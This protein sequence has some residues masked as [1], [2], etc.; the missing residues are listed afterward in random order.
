ML[1]RFLQADLRSLL[2]SQ[3]APCI[4]MYLPTAKTGA[5]VREG[6]I[7]LKNLAN[8][9]EQRL[10]GH[11]MSATDAARFLRPVA[12]LINDPEFWQ[13]T[14]EGLAMFLDA[15]Q[16]R[17]WRIDCP[18]REQ[19]AVSDQFFVQQI[20]SAANG[21]DRYY[22][23]ALGENEIALFAANKATIDKTEVPG[24]PENMEEALNLSSVDRGSQSHVASPSLPGKQGSVFHGQGGKP[25]RSREDLVTLYRQVNKAVADFLNGQQR[26]LILAGVESQMPA[27]RQVNSYPQ[28]LEPI[29]P[30][31]HAERSPHLLLE[32]SWPIMREYLDQRR[33]KALDIWRAKADTPATSSEI[34]EV[35]AGA[36]QGRLDHLF[37]DRSR[38]VSGQYDPA[39]QSI[40]Y[41]AK[42]DDLDLDLIEQAITQAVLH[43]TSVFS[44]PSDEMPNGAPMVAT[45]RY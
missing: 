32:K 21:D 42:T 27:Y 34:R 19:L 7:R 22:V 1:D 25:D 43:R 8:Q 11:W 23:L 36:C 31:A 6:R 39:S 40:L 16:L 28:L 45:L 30:G 2:T 44:L 14:D 3:N 37:F 18:F 26:P 38:S 12:E 20:V 15:N 41:E 24:L 5:E 9:A 35:V 10:T 17:R 33:E 4:S 29:V 13:H